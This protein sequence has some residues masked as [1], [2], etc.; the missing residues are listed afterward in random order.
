MTVPDS[1]TAAVV[2]QDMISQLF[3]MH[4]RTLNL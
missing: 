2:F 1:G 4:D 3:H